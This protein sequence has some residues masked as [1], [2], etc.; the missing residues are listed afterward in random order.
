MLFR[1]RY[2]LKSE[3]LS[4]AFVRNAA[5]LNK[6]VERSQK[7]ENPFLVIA[8]DTGKYKVPLKSI[9]YIETYKRNLMFHTEQ[10]NII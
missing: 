5:E 2:D 9:R 7:E 8:N 3:N 6:F 1:T 4:A 10:E